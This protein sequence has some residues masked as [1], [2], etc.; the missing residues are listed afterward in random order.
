MFGKLMR[1]PDG[2][3]AKF[4]RLCTLLDPAEV[5][6]IERGL[7][8]GS[9]RPN[10]AKRRLAREV[11]DLYQGPGAGTAA[12]QRF[13]LVHRE[14]AL[15]EEVPGVT[16]PAALFGP[17]GGGLGRLRTRAPRGAGPRG[18]P[19]RGAAAAGPGGVRMDGEPVPAEDIRVEGPLRGSWRD[20]SGR[21]ADGSSLAS[22]A[23]R[24]RG[25]LSE[26][27][28]RTAVRARALG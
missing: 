6:D 18:E 19:V 28:S 14:H 9:V 2:L 15:P 16:V 24:R 10:D 5:D 1:I 22:T 13:D 7:A 3:I 25:F 27:T 17:A 26:V 23:S 8:E 20:R 11:V 4:L 12:E 21:S